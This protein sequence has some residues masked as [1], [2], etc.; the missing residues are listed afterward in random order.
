MNVNV[1]THTCTH[2]H[3]CVCVCIVCVYMFRYIFRYI[4]LH[5][6]THKNKGVV[7]E[8]D[9]E[10]AE[11]ERGVE[12]GHGKLR[13]RDRPGDKIE[14]ASV[15]HSSPKRHWWQRFGKGAGGDSGKGAGGD[16][17]PKVEKRDGAPNAAPGP[18]SALPA[19]F[20]FFLFPP[21]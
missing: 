21:G 1:Y 10:H 13:Q 8:A 11:R 20:T 19:V 7:P 14:K 6:H 2:T 15:R 4:Y 18:P 17:E 16:S 9:N 3:R 5:T 12:R